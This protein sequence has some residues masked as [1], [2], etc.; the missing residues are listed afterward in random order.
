MRCASISNRAFRFHLILFFFLSVYFY[1]FM[2][3]S[4]F[5]LFISCIQIRFLH[6]TFA[7]TIRHHMLCSY[8]FRAQNSFRSIQIKETR[9]MDDDDDEK[10]IA[11]RINACFSIHFYLILFLIVRS[12]DYSC[13]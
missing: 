13:D 11:D 12:F 2:I 4:F 9:T 1:Y 6:F 10:M 8:L 5:L 7:F 3:F